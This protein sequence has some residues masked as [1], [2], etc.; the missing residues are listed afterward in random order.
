V[1]PIPAPGYGAIEA[2]INDL[3]VH[4]TATGHQVTVATTGDST[5]PVRRVSTFPRARSDAVDR[6][7]IET[8]HVLHA[9]DALRDVDLIHDHTIVGPVLGHR[10]GGPPV[11]TTC[12]WAI[13]ADVGRLYTRIAH[14]VPT[15][16]I[17]HSQ[18]RLAPGIP[19][20]RLVHQGV[21]IPRFPVGRG[22]GGYFLAIGRMDPTK[23]IHVAAE[24]AHRAGVRLLIA[25]PVR[26]DAE[27]RYFE[28]A[29]VV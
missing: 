25:G 13:T 21:D 19:F 17:S 18:R 4:L 15:I 1:A 27:R 29:V 28:T 16:A 24:V 11:V 9:Y 8:L 12:H 10:Q 3:A 14:E 26:S 2:I 7:S 22:D 5:V 20:A 6:S 23:G